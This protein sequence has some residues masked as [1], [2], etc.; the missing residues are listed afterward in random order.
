MFPSGR[1][2]TENLPFCAAAPIAVVNVLTGL[3]GAVV[4][5]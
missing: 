4:I 2:F 5:S 1:I 3:P